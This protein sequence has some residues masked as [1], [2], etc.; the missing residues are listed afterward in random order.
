MIVMTVIKNLYILMSRLLLTV[1]MV[2]EE[3]KLSEEDFLSKYERKKPM[4][5]D[6]IIF[7]CKMGGRAGKAA[8]VAVA[9]GFQK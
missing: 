2:E 3:L 6:E 7:H 8:D 9:L 1:S 4:A 5:D